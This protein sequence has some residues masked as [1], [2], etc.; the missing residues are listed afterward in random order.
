MIFG[1]ID[2]YSRKVC[3]KLN[4]SISFIISGNGPMLAINTFVSTCVHRSCTSGQQPTTEQA[5]RLHSFWKQWRNMVGPPGDL[6]SLLLYI[7]YCPMR[8][9]KTICRN[10]MVKANSLHRTLYRWWF[11]CMHK[12]F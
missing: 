6:C 7:K 10:A 12:V 4:T 2:G 9:Y 1:A 3:Y 5:Q 11:K 8:R